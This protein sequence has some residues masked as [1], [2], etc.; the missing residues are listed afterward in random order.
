MVH[1]HLFRRRNVNMSRR[2][3]H[4]VNESTNPPRD[5][6]YHNNED[7]RSGRDIPKNERVYTTG[8]YRLCMHCK[9][10]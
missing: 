3:Y 7:C 5:R 4:S 10:M 9:N 1:S 2:V 6:V 8:G